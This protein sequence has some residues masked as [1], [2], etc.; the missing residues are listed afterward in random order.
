MQLHI[1]IVSQQSVLSSV[2]CVLF[3][4]SLVVCFSAA[5]PDDDDEFV[6]DNVEIIYNF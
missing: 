1:Q 6:R 3:A 5:I 4:N 2:N